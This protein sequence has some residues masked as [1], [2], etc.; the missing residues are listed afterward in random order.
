MF[1]SNWL[2]D[3]GGIPTPLKNISQWEGLSHILWKIKT[4]PNHQP[5]MVCPLKLQFGGILHF[6][7]HPFRKNH[8]RNG[9]TPCSI[10]L[11]Y[12][13]TISLFLCGIKSLIC[14]SNIRYNLPSS[15]CLPFKIG[16]FTANKSIFR[17]DDHVDHVEN[18][19]KPWKMMVEHG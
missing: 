15:P 17:Q 13:G 11:G 1:I 5:V 16:G 4:V 3:V 8:S 14:R 12:F 7:I 2:V 19:E 6:H 18:Q 9:P 10:C